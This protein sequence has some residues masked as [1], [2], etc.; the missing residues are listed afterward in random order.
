MDDESKD[1]NCDDYAR[2]SIPPS[3][4]SASAIRRLKYQKNF[5]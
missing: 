1:K 4:A 3:R 2:E 5:L